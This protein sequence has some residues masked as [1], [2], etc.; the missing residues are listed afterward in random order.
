MFTSWGM[1]A[2]EDARAARKSPRNPPVV[3]RQRSTFLLRFGLENAAGDRDERGL[4]PPHSG[5]S[6]ASIS[7]SSMSREN[8]FQG[9]EPPS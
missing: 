1:E 8:G 6:N 2:D 9:L 3:F 5:P 7:P 4:C